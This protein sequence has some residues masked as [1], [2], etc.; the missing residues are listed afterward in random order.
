MVVSNRFYNRYVKIPLH[1]HT[2]P[3]IRYNPKLYPFFKDCRGAV[4]G[5]HIH[6]FVP[7]DAIPRIAIG[8]V[9]LVRTCLL[10]AHL[11]CDSAMFFRLSQISIESVEPQKTSFK[12]NYRQLDR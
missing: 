12:S 3:E 5:T 11:T 6:A 4:D 1:D 9:E 7:D 10:H 2:P 8:K